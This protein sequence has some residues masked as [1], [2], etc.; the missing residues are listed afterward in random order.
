MFEDGSIIAEEVL[1]L[2]SYI[3]KII[4]ALME[5]RTIK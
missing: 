1:A 2:F 4:Q 5:N 3:G